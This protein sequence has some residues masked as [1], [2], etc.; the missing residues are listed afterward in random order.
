MPGGGLYP[1]GLVDRIAGVVDRYT[2]VRLAAPALVQLKSQ[3]ARLAARVDGLTVARR[4]G[5]WARLLQIMLTIPH[6]KRMLEHGSR[7]AVPVVKLRQRVALRGPD[8]V[9]RR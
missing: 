6:V 9:H 4:R 7:P 3:H 5:Q 8:G 2:G 1:A